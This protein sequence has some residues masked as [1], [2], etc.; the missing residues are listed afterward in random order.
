M[1]QIPSS[2]SLTNM[3]NNYILKKYLAAKRGDSVTITN[4]DKLWEE[5]P[6]GW[7]INHLS[8]CLLLAVLVHRTNPGLVSDLTAIPTGTTQESICD[9]YLQAIG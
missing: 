7:W 8:C 1:H 5:I 3:K 6:D 4:D 9:R 2:K